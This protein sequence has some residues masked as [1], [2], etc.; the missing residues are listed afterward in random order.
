[1]SS[2]YKIDKDIFE[3]LDNGFNMACI[4]PETGEI[5]SSKVTAYLEAL[6]VERGIK[7]ENVA[8][9]IK[10]LESEAEI[11][12]A[13]E[14][15]LK[16]RREAKERKAERLR[17]YLKQSMLLYN[18]PTFETAKVSLSFK[19]SKAVVV[20]D[21]DILDKQYIREKVELSP[22]KTLIKKAIDLGLEVK[23]AHI[24]EKKNLQIK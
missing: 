22:D 11:I 7:V 24:E 9:F 8:V 6:Q 10:N 18:E 2:L 5:D 21:M 19:T 23:G 13:E 15:N 17:E 20:D 14:K 12:K 4:D 1:M 16:A 3:L